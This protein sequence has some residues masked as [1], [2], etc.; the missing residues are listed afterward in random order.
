MRTKRAS[1]VL[2]FLQVFAPA[3]APAIARAGEEPAPERVGAAVPPSPAHGLE[4][5]PYA[6]W[7]HAQQSSVGAFG[8]A[9][10]SYRLGSHWAVGLDG[11]LY[12]QASPGPAPSYP[13]NESAWSAN[14]D[15]AYLPWAP[16][17]EMRALEGY[18]MLPA[19][20]I[21]ATRPVAVVDPAN[22][23]FDLNYLVE[24]SGGIGARMYLGNSVALTLELRDMIYK[25]RRE[26]ALVASG[27]PTLSPADPNNPKN[28]ATWYAPT[29]AF[30][31]CV[32][33]RLGVSFFLGG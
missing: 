18:V 3:V 24:F 17:P 12:A 26:S 8:G 23:H 21:V 5:R 6:G 27:P 20:G 25:D 28:P 30:T 31:N 22:R 1:K 10:V 9:D 14:F 7:A 4:L 2:L 29:T 19:P 11:A 32:E 16:R 15:V 13:L 33:L